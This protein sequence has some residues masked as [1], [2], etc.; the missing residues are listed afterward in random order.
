MKV[1]DA[2]VLILPGLGGGGPD[3]WYDRWTKKLPTARRVEQA[4][5]WNP[6]KDVWVETV[7]EA[8]DAARKP[9]VLVGHSAGVVTIVHAGSQLA[10]RNVK[11][12]FLVAPPD[13]EAS[14]EMVPEGATLMPVPR[15]PLPVPSYLIASQNDPYCSFDA[16]GDLANA[17]GSE[18]F[19]AG[20][21]GHINAE[22]GHGPWPEG[23]LMLARFL[24]MLK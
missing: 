15:D 12:A 17:W 18:L 22:S 20:E 11:G 14:L 16:A 7:L 19:D 21:V 13:L 9:V 1:R 8:V 23:L 10:D 24:Q 4:D 6:D 2:D 3:Y 5:F